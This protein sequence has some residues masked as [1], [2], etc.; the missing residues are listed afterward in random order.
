MLKIYIAKIV[1]KIDSSILPKPLFQEISKYQNMQA[2]LQRVSSHL[3]LMHVLNLHQ[4]EDKSIE[5]NKYGK[6]FLG[7]KQFEFNL[8]HSGEYVACA[9]SDGAV[10]ID[11][12]LTNSN[13]KSISEYFLSPK[14]LKAY[15]S[16]SEQELTQ[17]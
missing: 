1:Q 5:V 7:N 6:P 2:R 17:I 8:S 11:L 13:I 9:I 4:V 3:L 15:V 16:S 12:E 14:E 10:G